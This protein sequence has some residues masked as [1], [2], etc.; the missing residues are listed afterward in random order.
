VKADEL[1]P[2]PN[3]LV[4]DFDLFVEHVSSKAL[5]CKYEEPVLRGAKAN[6]NIHITAITLPGNERV[7]NFS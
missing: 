2:S 1:L 7:G 3:L 6:L 5:G 4:N